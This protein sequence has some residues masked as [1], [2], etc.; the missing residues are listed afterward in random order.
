MTFSSSTMA[1]GRPTFA[2]VISAKR[3]VPTL[4][5]VKFTTHSPVRLS[6]PARAFVRLAPSTSTRRRTAKRSPSRSPGRNITP[7]GG[8]EASDAA[9]STR[10]KVMRAVRPSRFLI[11]SGSSTPGR[12]TR[13]R[14]CPWR[15]ISASAT[16]V[17]STRR[18]T[19]SID[20]S[21][22]PVALARR[23]ASVSVAQ[24][25]PSAPLVTS[26]SG[27]LCPVGNC[28]GFESS[29]SAAT[30]AGTWDASVTRRPMRRL[31]A[32]AERFT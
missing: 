23:P 5:K 12:V 31:G 22:A 1:K 2:R 13:M 32:S 24:T 6:C 7:G 16:P 27:T 19:I 3:R 26:M 8:V 25:W 20:C 11:R 10:W 15:A 30:A 29:R 17:S 14:C 9:S 28:T 21:T 4:S 18:R